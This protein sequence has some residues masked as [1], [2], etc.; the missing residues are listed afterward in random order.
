MQDLRFPFEVVTITTSHAI[1]P[2]QLQRSYETL[3]DGFLFRWQA[4]LN[5]LNLPFGKLEIPPLADLAEWYL[6]WREKAL[7]S[8]AEADK[9]GFPYTDDPA[10][11][12]KTAATMWNWLPM[13]RE[14][15]GDQ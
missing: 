3:G 14:G 10:L 4:D 6:T 11:A 5:D 9:Y 15:N 2:A 12:K 7:Y 13:L 8:P 1:L